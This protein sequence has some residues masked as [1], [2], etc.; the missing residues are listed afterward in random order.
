MR[1]LKARITNYRSV[2]DS[3]EFSVDDTLCLVGKNEAG[4]DVH[5][6]SSSIPIRPR[7][8]TSR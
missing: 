3:E 4:T 8:E 6:L 2:E 7:A 1:L 5:I